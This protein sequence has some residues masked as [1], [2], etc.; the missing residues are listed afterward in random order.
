MLKNPPSL[1]HLRRSFGRRFLIAIIPLVSL[2][3]ATAADGPQGDSVSQ[4]EARLREIDA[5]LAGLARFTL[6]SGAGNI[7]WISMP[8]EKDTDVEWAEISLP[9]DTVIDQIVLVPVLWNDAEQGPLATGFPAEFKIIAGSEAARNGQEIAHLGLGENFL[10][11]VAPLVVDVPP[12]TADWI[13]IESVRLSPAARI[14]K[15]VFN[16]SE[17]LIF[18]EERNVALAQPVRVSSTVGGW[19]ATAIYKESL[20][21]GFTP[22]VMDAS[23]EVSSPYLA[24]FDSEVSYSLEVDLGESFPIEEIRIHSSDASE[25]IP[26]INPID[27]GIP[28]HLVVTGSHRPDF[29]EAKTLLSYRRDSV[30][31]AG[32]ILTR[33]VTPTPCRYI[34][35]SI[36]DPYQMPIR[37]RPGSSV[38]IA[39][40]EIISE[41]Q[42]VARGKTVLLQRNRKVTHHNKPAITD[43][44]NHFG[45]ILSPREWMGQLA[46]RHELETQRPLIASELNRKYLLQ[47]ANLTRMYWIAALLAAGIVFTILVGR[48]LRM[49]A[50]LKTRERI[51]A[52][53]HD[54][55]SANLH[56]LA[57]LGDMAKKHLRSPDKMEEVIERI[58]HLSQRSRNAARHC[59]N[60]LQANTIGEDLIEEISYTADRL[61]ADIPYH[62]SFEGEGHL[63][64]L[65]RRTRNDLFLFIKECLTN[66]V[67]HAEATRCQIRL[68]G[69]PSRITLDV[70]DNGLG[71]KQV[72]PSLNRRARLLRAKVSAKTPKDSGTRISLSFLTIKGKLTSPR[73]APSQPTP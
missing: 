21:D 4:L 66:I 11:R 40:L 57:L 2:G 60:M 3:P 27:F 64:S 61:L 26:Q 67:R 19:G 22:F 38:G 53:L 52:N 33:N 41:G 12:T 50:I 10:P 5:E 14:G 65:P 62:L 44:R 48:I 25:H 71:V 23:G 72:P 68:V 49:R 58:Q 47:K 13:R 36:P 51:A 9:K 69:S 34:R 31:E 55:L 70:T 7:G 35:L 1:R 30:Y 46:R 8:N 24:F 45:E 37:N 17:I 56:G 73:K 18:S 42:N 15:P 28:Y 20:T 54:E 59:T 63:Q 43:G 16:L 32:P 39:E 29:S 6:R